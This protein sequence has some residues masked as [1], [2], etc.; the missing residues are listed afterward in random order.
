MSPKTTQQRAK[1]PKPKQNKPQALNMGNTQMH[2]AHTIYNMKD[3][4]VGITVESVEPTEA[5][6]QSRKTK[7][8][9]W[10]VDKQNG[11]TTTKMPRVVRSASERL[12]PQWSAK[13][14]RPCQQPT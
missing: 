6:R 12:T 8:S 2:N 1:R 4:V 5:E 11:S 13:A 9:K 14:G 10:Q 7:T 3:D